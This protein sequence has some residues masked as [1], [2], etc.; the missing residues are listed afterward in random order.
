MT[1]ITSLYNIRQAI[2]SCRKGNCN[3]CKLKNSN[4]C[5]L[6]ILKLLNNIEEG[7]NGNLQ[8]RPKNKNSQKTH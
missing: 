3:N 8:I 2:S 5:M 7:L 4:D 6:D 1:V